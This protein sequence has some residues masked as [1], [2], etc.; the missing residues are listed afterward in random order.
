MRNAALAVFA[1]QIYPLPYTLIF[2]RNI[3]LS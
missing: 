1:A 2:N 3:N